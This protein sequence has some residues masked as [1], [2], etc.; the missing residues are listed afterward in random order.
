[1]RRGWSDDVLHCRR[2][3]HMFRCPYRCGEE[4]S[5]NGEGRGHL[6][7]LQGF[8]VMTSLLLHQES[9]MLHTD[10]PQLLREPT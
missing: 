5:F 10:S 8:T 1:M 7:L 2:C 3:V 4:R 6:E 9:C